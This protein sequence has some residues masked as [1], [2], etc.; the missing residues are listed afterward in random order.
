MRNNRTFLVLYTSLD[1]YQKK[2][3]L[4]CYTCNTEAIPLLL[5]FPLR[6]A[7]VFNIMVEG[8]TGHVGS[9]DIETCLNNLEYR[10]TTT[11]SRTEINTKHPYDACTQT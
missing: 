3:V 7:S 8:V 1:S 10:A 4:F 2:F 5:L 11:L 6:L 9:T